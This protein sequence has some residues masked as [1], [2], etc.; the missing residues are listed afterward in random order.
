VNY[1]PEDDIQSKHVARGNI[2][3]K[4]KKFVL[5]YDDFVGFILSVTLAFY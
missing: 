4:N 3:N 2:Y 1:S 5:T